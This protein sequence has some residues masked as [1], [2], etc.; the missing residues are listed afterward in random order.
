M[1]EFPAGNVVSSASRIA[2]LESLC[3]H[4]KFL[5]LAGLVQAMV[6]Y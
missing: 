1:K 5:S 6:G 2:F 4:E 3:K